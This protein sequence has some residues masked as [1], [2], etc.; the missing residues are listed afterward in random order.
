MNVLILDMQEIKSSSKLLRVFYSD[1]GKVKAKQINLR[2]K[3]DKWQTRKA[4]LPILVVCWGVLRRASQDRS[5][6][7]LKTRRVKAGSSRK[8]PFKWEER[9]KR[10]EINLSA[11]QATAWNFER[12]PPKKKNKIEILS[13]YERETCE[14][15]R[16]CGQNYKLDKNTN[17]T[18][19]QVGQHYKLDK[20]G[21]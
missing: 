1:V 2:N 12:P 21:Q 3:S 7:L 14:H 8:Q 4:T 20:I 5:K 13:I 15:I 16:R 18:K 17:W 11:C 19:L 6:V 9:E 10:I